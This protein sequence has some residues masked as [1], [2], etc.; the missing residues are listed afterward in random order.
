MS[1]RRQRGEAYRLR[2]K[3]RNFAKGRRSSPFVTYMDPKMV[4]MLK[5]P[6]VAAQLY[7]PKLE[8]KIATYITVNGVLQ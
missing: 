6:L 4:D 8:G 1:R 7:G 2:R 3:F 5:A